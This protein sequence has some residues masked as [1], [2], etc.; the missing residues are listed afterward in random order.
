MFGR[1]KTTVP[2]WAFPMDEGRYSAFISAVDDYF[3]RRGG[4]YNIDEGTV[5]IGSRKFGL[6]NLVQMC[7]KRSPE[8]YP[9]MAEHHFTLMFESETFEAGLALDDFEKIKQ[10]IGVRLYGK[11]Y[12]AGFGK[13]IMICR[14]FAEGVF[15]ALIFDLPQTVRNISR[16]NAD[17]WNRSDDEL[18]DIGIENIRRSYRLETQEVELGGD[19]V[20]TIETEHFFASNILFDI[21]QN[22]RFLGKGGA[23]IAIPTRSLAAIYPINDMRTMSVLTTFFDFVPKFYA[24]GPGSLTDQV[25]WY[26]DGRYEPLDYET[27]KKIKFTPSEAFMSLLN[28]GL[29]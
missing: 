21:E 1:K 4:T 11:E 22:K 8:E 13:D 14:P 15:A 3:K 7:A 26:H 24:N 19:T 9:E 23:L 6:I 25:F 29:E 27:G 2:E 20:F 18:F 10:Y 28:G 12:I 16:F 5:Y 17:K